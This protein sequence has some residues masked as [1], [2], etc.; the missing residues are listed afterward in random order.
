M[1]D[2]CIVK[3][4]FFGRAVSSPCPEE[5]ID[6]D[7]EGLFEIVPAFDY[8]TAVTVDKE[9]EAGGNGFTIKEDVGSFLEVSDPEV[10]GM[11]TSPAYAHLLVRDA[12]LKACCPCK[13]EMTI[14][15]RFGYGFPVVL[16]RNLLRQSSLRRGCTFLSSMALSIISL[17]RLL[18]VP[19]SDRVFRAG[20]RNPPLRYW[21][22]F[23]LRVEMLGLFCFP[24]GKRASC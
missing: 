2:F 8:V 6:K 7:M 22:S 21:S 15:G 24:L 16:C 11:V 3:A 19:R 18:G 20:D 13:S 4:E 17:E 5:G 14:E 9:A 12:E 10:V 23:R 1:V